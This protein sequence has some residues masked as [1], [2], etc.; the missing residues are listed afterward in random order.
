M[1]LICKALLLYRRVLMCPK[2]ASYVMCINAVTEVRPCHHAVCIREHPCQKFAS[3][4]CIRGLCSF[5]V[6]CIV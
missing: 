5:V 3:D 2:D 4:S 6:L 1:H